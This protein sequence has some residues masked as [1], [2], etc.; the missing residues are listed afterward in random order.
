MATRIQLD[1]A[2]LGLDDYERV[3][4]ALNFPAD[5]PQGL[6]AH[7]S[8]EADGHLRVVDVW[9][10]A[11]AFDAFVGSRLM[12]AIGEAL[13]DRAEQPERSDAELHSFYTR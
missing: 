10:S 3:C 13:G 2:T 11:S 1:F 9:E 8:A 12:P 5:W 4:E 6:L 7:G